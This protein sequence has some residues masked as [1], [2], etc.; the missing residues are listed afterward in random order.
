MESVEA[1]FIN[2]ILLASATMKALERSKKPYL[3]PGKKKASLHTDAL[4]SL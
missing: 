3:N 1:G 2:L 4:A